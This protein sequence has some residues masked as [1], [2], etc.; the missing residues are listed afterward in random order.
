MSQ[1]VSEHYGY[2]TSRMGIFS[3]TT[4][5]IC[6]DAH[7]RIIVVLTGGKLIRIYF[8]YLLHAIYFSVTT[9][10]CPGKKISILPLADAKLRPVLSRR[11][12]LEDSPYHVVGAMCDKYISPMDTNNNP[13]LNVQGPITRARA[14]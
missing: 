12:L 5:R 7:I 11:G 4:V 10:L 14:R 3:K 1:L 9:H 13:P 6:L 2:N 8:L